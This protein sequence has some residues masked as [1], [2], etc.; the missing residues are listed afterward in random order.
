MQLDL[1]GHDLAFVVDVLVTWISAA[2]LARCALVLGRNEARSTLEKRTQLL[3][4][5][6]A[7]GFFTRGFSWLAPASAVLAFL[8]FMPIAF[9]P[10]AMTLFVE[11]LL[12]RHVPL[13]VKWLTAAA[14]VIAFLADCLRLVEPSNRAASVIGFVML[15]ALL[16][17]LAALGLVLARA[18]RSE[19]SRSELGLI[20]ICSIIAPFGLAFA[21]TDF[22]HDLGWPQVRM[23]SLGALVFCYSLIRLPR[24]NAQ[25]SEW[26]RDLARMVVRALAACAFLAFALQTLRPAVLFP[27]SVLAIAIIF[28]MAVLDRLRD[29]EGRTGYLDLLEWLAREPT[30][31]REAFVAE[32]K[33]LPLTADAVVVDEAALA[34]YDRDVIARVFRPASTVLSLARLRALREG[35]SPVARGA[36]DLTDLLESRGATHVG[37]LCASPTS[38]LVVT[39]PDLGGRDIELA[40]SAVTRRWPRHSPAIDAV[41]R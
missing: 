14:T 13:G 1:G 39:V 27:L 24:E 34:P 16:I 23:G 36:D 41:T 22:R 21:I 26:I 35:T 28:S 6:L 9:L 18:N 7:L 12:R 8:A 5:T 32:L 38:L 31:T 19:L 30:A 2:T 40:L 3:L 37:L 29:V 4:G 17:T 33:T 15:V 10:L 20:R 25:P 11:G